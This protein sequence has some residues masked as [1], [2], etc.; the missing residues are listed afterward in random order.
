[1]ANNMTRLDVCHG[2]FHNTFKPL[3]AETKKNVPK[4]DLFVCLGKCIHAVN[5]PKQKHSDGKADQIL[6]LMRSL[7]F[8]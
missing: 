2:F 4:S 8:C 7:Y 3:S 1:M 5:N 6:E